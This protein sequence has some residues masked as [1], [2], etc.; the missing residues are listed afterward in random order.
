MTDNI[1]ASAATRCSHESDP[2]V[3]A[4]CEAT[5]PP[6]WVNLMLG[7]LAA[8]LVVSQSEGAPTLGRPLTPTVASLEAQSSLADTR[9]P[10]WMVQLNCVD[11]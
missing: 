3:V 5:G 9:S 8:S 1:A 2:L 11:A 6:I 4:L 10:P 7:E